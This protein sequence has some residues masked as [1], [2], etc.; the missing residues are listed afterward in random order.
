MEKRGFQ[1]CSQWNP[2]FNCLM[3]KSNNC[4][5]KFL[6]HYLIFSDCGRKHANALYFQIPWWWN[7]E[8]DASDSCWTW[9]RRWRRWWRRKHEWLIFG[10]FWLYLQNFGLKK[11]KTPFEKEIW[12]KWWIFYLKNVLS[13]ISVYFIVHLFCLFLI[14][15]SA[16]IFE[17]CIN[18]FSI[19]YVWKN[20][21]SFIF[22]F[23]YSLAVSKCL[24]LLLILLF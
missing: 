15:F 19:F 20:I 7:T 21:L 1:W 8:E 4:C 23:V 22:F 3:E 11:K 16:S 9:D 24:S 5:F 12:K 13:F 17:L 6:S 14:L 18:F 2:T 10:N